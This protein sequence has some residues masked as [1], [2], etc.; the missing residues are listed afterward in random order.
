MALQWTGTNTPAFVPT[1]PLRVGATKQRA[2][3]TLAHMD[4]TIS[5]AYDP[6]APPAPSDEE[7]LGWFQPVYDALKADGW[8]FHTLTQDAPGAVRQIEE[9]A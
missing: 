7:V 8:V 6:D 2:N 3:F 4:F 9:V 5:F 1:R